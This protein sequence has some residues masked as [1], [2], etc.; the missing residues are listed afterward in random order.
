MSRAGARVAVALGALVGVCGGGPASAATDGPP[1]VIEY[2][3][4]A[5]TV[6]LTSVPI[7][8]VLDELG[9]QAGAA[10]QG[11]VR[12]P[13]DVSI[14]FDRVPLPQALHRLLGDQNFTL[15][16]GEGG[17]L[18]AVK[19]LGGP[20][21]ARAAPP[22]AAGAAGPPADP[23]AAVANLMSMVAA[24]AAVPVGGRL[25]EALKT[26]QTSVQQLVDASL[27]NEDPVV[28]AAA[29]RRTLAVLEA[30]PDLRSAVLNTLKGMEDADV[31][32]V[33]QAVSA[34]HAEEVVSQV[35][36]QARAS[37][38]RVKAS[39]VLQQLRSQKQGS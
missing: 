6:R 14:E 17:R 37:E 20:Q 21:A 32:R 10:I 22:P 34:S 3:Q 9:Q 4:D 19:L 18:R 12:A 33:L 7:G 11:G 26:E 29:V 31:A 16:Y 38:L 23:Q 2:A 36:A 8:E 35:A 28:R 27:R 15:V 5:L 13:R 30:E 24:H 39:G 25:A 1:R